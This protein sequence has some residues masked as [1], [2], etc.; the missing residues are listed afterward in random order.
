MNIKPG[1]LVFYFNEYKK[2]KW[3]TFKRWVK[4]IS[5]NL[6]E[7]VQH[8]EIVA[9]E[10]NGSDRLKCFESTLKGLRYKHANISQERI[11]I[12]TYK[13]DISPHKIITAI[14]NYY[15]KTPK[16]Y[17][18][19]G[20]LNATLNLILKFLTIGFWK[21]RNLFVDEAKAFCSEAVVEVWKEAGVNITHIP[22]GVVS[23]ADLYFSKNFS[24][25]KDFGSSIYDNY[26][27]NKVD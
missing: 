22:D 14:E 25:K 23:P 6:G 13:D 5:Y 2:Y 7:I 19:I 16:A 26:I 9:E 1:D 8:V 17:S 24:I 3:Y 15:K 18:K 21:K 10:S 12:K 20:Y 27:T 11:M 4:Q